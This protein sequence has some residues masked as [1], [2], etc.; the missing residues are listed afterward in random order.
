MSTLTNIQILRSAV[1]HKRPDP[2]QLLDGQL[3]INYKD[4]D[5]GLFTLL[6]NGDLVKFGPV[7]VT[8]DGTYPNQNPDGDGHPG[9]SKGEE[10]LDG[11]S[12]YYSDILK[13]YGRYAVGHCKR[14]HS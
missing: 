4:T 14:L 1:P 2:A 13:I 7:S 8:S 3:A 11:R 9:N 6:Q 12:E 10:W 5:P